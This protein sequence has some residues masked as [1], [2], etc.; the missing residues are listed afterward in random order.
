MT[1]EDLVKIGFQ[2]ITV[3]E[4]DN[5]G[6]SSYDYY[7]YDVAGD[8]VLISDASDECENGNFFVSLFAHPDMGRTDDINTTQQI[9]NCLL[10]FK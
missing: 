9:I 2:K 8:C 6:V 3:P 7:T 1:G 5:D 10:R 4:M